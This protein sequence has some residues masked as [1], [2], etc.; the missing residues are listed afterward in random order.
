MAEWVDIPGAIRVADPAGLLADCDINAV[1]ASVQTYL[2]TWAFTW[3]G[4]CPGCQH[5][6]PL[7]PAKRRKSVILDVDGLHHAT[8]TPRRCRRRDCPERGFYLW[9]SFQVHGRKVLRWRSA[10]KA[11][12]SVILLTQRFGVTRRW[13]QQFSKRLVVQ[14]ASFWGEAK[15]HWQPGFRLSFNRFKLKLEDAWF[16]IRL[17]ERYWQVQPHVHMSLS[18]DKE[19]LIRQVGDAYDAF[20]MKIRK[21]QVTCSDKPLL[22]LVIDGHVKAGARRRCGVPSVSATLCQPLQAWSLTTCPRTPAYKHK[23]CPWHVR[24]LAAFDAEPTAVHS[25]SRAASLAQSGDDLLR[26]ILS[27]RGAH[28]EKELSKL[29]RTENMLVQGYLTAC[30]R[31]KSLQR[32]EPV[33]HDGT[34]LQELLDLQRQTHKQGDTGAKSHRAGGLLVACRSDGLIVHV[35]EYHGAESLSQRYAFIAHLKATH[36]SLQV[37]VHDDACHLRRFAHNRFAA[38]SRKHTYT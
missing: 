17:L 5:I 36:S 9:C 11:L 29:T 1:A 35:Q 19:H 2:N 23:F 18:A 13:Y 37:L 33:I 25:V 14:M 32:V 38:A 3:S 30:H 12:P 15:V 28:A 24:C 34:T 20:M 7:V 21:S 26:V 16:K 6:P 31:A 4:P 22:G 8:H 27:Q 10:V